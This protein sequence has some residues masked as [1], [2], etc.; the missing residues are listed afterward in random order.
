MSLRLRIL[1][2]LVGLLVLGLAAFGVGVNRLMRDKLE[3]QLDQQLVS[4]AGTVRQVLSTDKDQHNLD[5]LFDLTPPPK[6]AAGILRTPRHVADTAV[7][8]PGLVIEVR[9]QTGTV[10]DRQ[11]YFPK[12]EYHPPSSSPPQTTDVPTESIP[13]SMRQGDHRVLTVPMNEGDTPVLVT[14]A[15]QTT[16]VDDVL[17]ELTVIELALGVIIVVIGAGLALVVARVTAR[18]LA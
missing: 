2:G 17:Q 8:P 18:P 3:S 4:V 13:A 14:L 15:I 16:A 7:F 12:M 6:A 9:S 5:R 10:L 1:A 11:M